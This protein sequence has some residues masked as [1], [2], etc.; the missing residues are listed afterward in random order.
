M[1]FYITTYAI[2]LAIVLLVVFIELVAHR[3]IFADN[4]VIQKIFG[5]PMLRYTLR[6]VG[7]ALISVLLA[8]IVTFFL[9]RASTN[10]NTLCYQR[11]FGGQ[12][13]K[14]PDYIVEIRCAQFAEEMG[15][16]GNPFQQLFHFLYSILPF[17]K[18]LCTSYQTMGA[19][20]TYYTVVENC[21]PFIMDL[22]RIFSNKITGLAQPVF[23][24]DY[25]VDRMAVSFP[26]MM[27]ASLLQIAIGYPV[28]ILMAKYKNGVFD[29]VGNA[30]IV[31]V[32]A[33]PGVA[34]YY[35][36][37]GIFAV[38]MPGLTQYQDGNFLT[39]LPPILTM[40]LTGFTG[41][42]FWVRR[43]MV[44][45]FNSDYV[46]FA[47]AKGLSEGK[48]MFKHVLRNAV[49]PLARTFPSAVLGS[50]F[51]SFFI[52]KIYSIPGIGGLLIQANDEKEFFALQGIVIISALISVVSY[53]LG[54]VVTAIADPRVRF[55][56][57]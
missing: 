35:I 25:I 26:I 6:R 1:S 37:L 21:R 30:Y 29:H 50:L 40:A 10:I 48:I 31:T 51:G 12:P 22:G 11:E 52:E 41:I 28:G 34:L 13:Q 20:G 15:F 56:K 57:E 24:L 53:L 45:E 7:S 5:H 39:W 44:D 43:Y 16:A 23:V 36:F 47:R 46:K 2:L 3:V 49:V 17:P 33:V 19:D 38:I 27:I 42:A 4:R 14:Y 18:L 8:I 9:I 32:E 54:D 55:S